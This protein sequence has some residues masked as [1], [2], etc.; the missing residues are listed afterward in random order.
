M[1]ILNLSDSIKK[2]FRRQSIA[3]NDF[4]RFLSALKSLIANVND[5][6]TE[7]MQKGHLTDFLKNSFY[8]NYI[9]GPAEGNI[10]LAIRLDNN[11]SSNVAV[12]FE[13]K[14]TTNTQEM[15]SLESLNRKALQELVLYYLR[16]RDNGNNDIKYLV[17]TNLIDFFIFDAQLFERLFFKN[18]Q[19]LTEYRDFAAGRKTSSKTDFFYREIAAKYIG[20]IYD[21]LEF[22]H[23]SLINYK[24]LIRNGERS[25]K[26]AELYRI[27][28]PI[29]LL[30]L[31][32]LNDSNSLNSAFYKE[33]LHLIG[34]AEYKENG[35]VVIRRVQDHPNDASLIENTIN[36]VQS[37]GVIPSYITGRTRNERLFN[38]A[39]ELN[40]T[41]IN[42]ILFLK[43]LEAQLINYHKGD[44]SYRF[45]TYERIP[46][47]DTL[48]R[49]FFQVL[50]VE[51]DFRSQTVKD[52]FP[53]IPYLNSSLF[54]VSK[55]ERDIIR[56]SNLSQSELM[57]L[58]SH[59][60]LLKDER[61]RKAK[62]LPF[63]QYLFAFLDAYD[64]ASEGS[65]E[66]QEKSKT[67]IN[68]SV[69]GLIF[70]KIN[71]YKDGSVFTPGFI[72]SYMCRES[73]TKV[74]VD[75]FNAK[76]GWKLSSYEQLL[77]AD[78]PNIDEANQLINSIT[79]CDPAVGS[80]H[81]LVS[82]LNEII[83]IKYE[84]GILLDVEGKRIKKSEYIV[85]I[86]ND[87]LI[88]SDVD[89]ELWS[90]NPVNPESRRI[91]QALFN[92]KR[93]IIESCLFGV[94]IN[95][96]SVN[97][98]RLR[99]WIELLKNA[100]YTPESN[101]T[102]L[103][104]L[105][106]IDINIKCG[107]SMLHQY[108]LTGKLEFP[109]I[110]EYRELV[111]RYK[112]SKSKEDKRELESRIAAIKTAFT[113]LLNERNP[114]VSSYRKAEARLN[115]ITSQT[116]FDGNGASREEQRRR[117]QEKADAEKAFKEAKAALDKAKTNAFFQSGFEWRIEFPEILDDKG[118]F[119]GFDLIIGNPPYLKEGRVDKEVFTK[120][121]YSPYY[122]GK[123]D[124][125]YMFACYGI[126]LLKPNG[127]LS[128]IATNNWVTN[129]GALKLRKKISQDSQ[130]LQL[131]D[132][133][134]LF[135]FDTA[136]I[137]TMILIAQKNS[138]PESYVFDY[139][140]INPDATNRELINFSLNKI[141]NDEIQYILPTFSRTKLANSLFSFAVG[142]K[143]TLLEKIANIG[144][145]HLNIDSSKDEISSGIDVLQDKL[146]KKN[147]FILQPCSHNVG[148]GIFVLSD[149]EKQLLTF[150]PNELEI[151][152]PFYTSTEI[153]RY[154][155]NSENREWIIYAGASLNKRIEDFPNIK[156]HLD[157]FIPI[158]TSVNKPYGLHR[159][160]ARESFEGEKILVHRKSVGR[161]AFSYVEFDSF[162]SRTFMVIKSNRINLKFLTG[163]LNSKLVE[164][165]LRNRGKMQGANFQLDKEPL[166]QIPIVKPSI[167]KQQLVADLVSQIISAKRCDKN[168]DTSALERQI[169][170][171]VYRL[172]GLS[173]S[174][175]LM[176]D[177]NI[178]ILQTNS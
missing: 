170:F 23:F 152:K 118:S 113:D 127:Y 108:E 134:G 13:V 171:I 43:L 75:K 169:D 93:T 105:P 12:V 86:E 63:L 83:H 149:E 79:L 77:N 9:V 116:L 14:S 177:P 54:E 47:F 31:P 5:E 62:N 8:S 17:V 168:A 133:G 42:R 106:N 154:L 66:I 88:V 151:I 69:L 56:M 165:W 21:D 29:H 117:K 34:L 138:A 94:D 68:A 162:V 10:D 167:D 61:F 175:I 101:F 124:I 111:R 27:F 130:I 132:F 176:I 92:E 18:K 87:E 36:I 129:D 39:M 20:E 122:V 65:D 98:C 35:K 45:L 50:G 119:V 52:Q 144:S 82:A 2:T 145:F 80:G 178:D 104:T 153:S 7:E 95:P 71:G 174:D 59:S 163:L 109:K 64:F 53:R 147:H 90:Y 55:P 125:W 85:S 142:P 97:I 60:V 3:S 141:E 140:R 67:L 107:N 159:T 48:N 72:T 158:L 157:D 96:N 156:K 123:M 19:L 160:R 76:Y 1:K 32:F 99:L 22:T 58:Y 49:L 172:Y 78:L 30:K 91:Q 164:F 57:P 110:K 24:H 73:I 128:F 146:N 173:S 148:D 102:R 155:A 25:R 11:V 126:D 137:Q 143:E 121:K 74:V 26:L 15:I 84:L 51:E 139:R 120:L 37:D 131:C 81:F 115:F 136:S 28:N 150:L 161:P 33:L 166:Q 103:E 112:T 16:E 100:Y 89:G 70:E 46:D 135:V 6:Q 38:A 4:N 44:Q 114:V 41:W 40:I